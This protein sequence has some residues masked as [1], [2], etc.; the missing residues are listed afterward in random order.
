[1]SDHLK[2]D[3]DENGYK[4]VVIQS[5]YTVFRGQRYECDKITTGFFGEY[6]VANIYATEPGKRLCCYNFTRPVRL[7]LMDEDNIRKL[8]DDENVKKIK[9]RD[10]DSVLSH[11]KDSY[12]TSTEHR[13]SFTAS[14][15]LVVIALCNSIWKDKYDGYYGPKRKQERYEFKLDD[16]GNKIPIKGKFKQFEKVK[17]ES[18]FPREIALCNPENVLKLCTKITYEDLKNFDERAQVDDSYIKAQINLIDSRSGSGSVR[19]V[20][21]DYFS[22][23]NWVE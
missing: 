3:I 20:K 12:L 17:I 16:Q 8:I 10:G 9:T 14:D 18:T 22:E 23:S 4:Y 21:K 6:N 19:M 1:M 15:V 2:V 13:N 7:F 5:G 11:L